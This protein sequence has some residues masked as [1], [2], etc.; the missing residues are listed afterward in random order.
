M[1]ILKYYIQVYFYRIALLS[2][3]LIILNRKSHKNEE[4]K[5]QCYA[6]INC[7]MMHWFLGA[8]SL[9]K[10]EYVNTWVDW[11]H[12]RDSDFKAD[13]MIIF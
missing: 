8:M 6:L 2:Y 3:V 12:A 13:I 4:Y 5:K 9:C 1:N 7:R 11:S 10:F